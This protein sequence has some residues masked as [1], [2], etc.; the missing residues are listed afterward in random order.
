[1]SNK[2]RKHLINLLKIGVTLGGLALVLREVKP[3]LILNTLAQ[4]QFGWVL[5]SFLLINASL[6]LRAYRW[7]ILLRGVGAVIRL[8]RL[9]EL[10]FVGSFF[11]MFLLSGFGGDVVRI[12]EAARS[13]PGSVAAGTV[14]LDR[15]TGLIML[16]VMALFALPFRPDGFPDYVVWFVVA[17]AVGGLLFLTLL[18]QKRFLHWLGHWLPGPL[19]TEGNTPIARLLAAVEGCGWRAVGSALFIS[20]LFNLLLALWWKTSSLALGLTIPYAYF[21]LV[22]PV[23]SVLLMIPS[24]SGLGPPEAMSPLLFAAAGLNA[25]T[26]VSLSFL[27]FLTVRFSG[28]LGAPVYLWTTIRDGRKSS[29]PAENK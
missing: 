23:L 16:F 12:L 17:G 13:V 19:K 1:M 6:A 20:L 4:A 9:V 18:M 15:F 14:L 5:V 10:Y 11:N 2:T 21:V 7:S 8:G 26:A 22:V 25:E 27:V 28:L 3:A 24:V 29:Q